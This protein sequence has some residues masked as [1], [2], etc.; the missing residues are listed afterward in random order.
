VKVVPFLLL[1]ATEGGNF[2]AVTYMRDQ[3]VACYH[4][5]FDLEYSLV[6]NAIKCEVYF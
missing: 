5:E 1:K 3:P 4:D 2:K 6:Y